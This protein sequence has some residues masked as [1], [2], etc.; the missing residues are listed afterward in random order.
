MLAI[1]NVYVVMVSMS[2]SEMRSA[3]PSIVR[4]S[5]QI[6]E[7]EVKSLRKWGIGGVKE[8]A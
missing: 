5:N 1:A 2:S 7:T 3:M 6:S 8:R 4:M